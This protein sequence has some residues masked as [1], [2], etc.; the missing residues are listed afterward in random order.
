MAKID[1]D[2]TE[3]SVGGVKLKGVYI[4]VVLSFASTIAGGIFAASKFIHRIDTLETRVGEIK[5]PDGEPVVKLIENVD[6]LTSEVKG[7]QNKQKRKRGTA[8]QAGRSA[9]RATNANSK[10]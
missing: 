1:L 7:L 5:M 3:L 2:S 6:F 8:R 4:A 10:Q 9:Q